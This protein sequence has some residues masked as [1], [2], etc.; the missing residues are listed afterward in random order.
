MKYFSYLKIPA[1]KSCEFFDPRNE[2]PMTAKY[3]PVQYIILFQFEHD[4]A[5]TVCSGEF[6][7]QMTVLLW[8]CV[9]SMHNR[10][11][12]HARTSLTLPCFGSVNYCLDLL[13]YI[14]LPDSHVKN[15][16]YFVF[17]LLEVCSEF[18]YWCICSKSWLLSEWGKQA[19]DKLRLVC[20]FQN[21]F[22]LWRC[23]D[24]TEQLD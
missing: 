16:T 11:V 18:I 6:C 9:D 1:W 5:N 24:K 4:G 12:R 20:S 2:W 14:T 23:S 15:V 22:P 8:K 3:W 13:A 19:R 7:L 10:S 17:V 21:L